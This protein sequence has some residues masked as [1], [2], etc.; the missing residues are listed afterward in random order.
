MP[1]VFG[2]GGAKRNVCAAICVDG[3]IRAACEQERLTR[4][5]GIGLVPGSLPVEAV[6]EVIA[7]ADCR[8]ET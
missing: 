2:I 3:Q 1:A 5:R 4:V 7:L 6:D 8:P